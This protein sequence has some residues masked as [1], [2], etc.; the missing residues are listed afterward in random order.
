MEKP[1]L[2]CPLCNDAVDRLVYR[3]HYDTEATVITRIKAEFPEWTKNDGLCSRCLDFFHTEIVIEQRILPSVGPHFPVKTSDDFLVI[4]AG[5]RIN[6]DPRF[7]GKGVTICFIDS[8]FCLHPD[9]IITKNRIKKIVDVATVTEEFQVSSDENISPALWHGTMTSVVCSGDGYLSAGLYKGIASDAELVLIKVMNQNGHITTENICKALRWILDN[10]NKYDIRI[11][12]MSLGDEIGGSYKESEVDS[13]CEQL[14]EKGIT[15]VAAVGN[16]QHGAIKPPA[17]APDVIAVGGVDDENML[18]AVPQKLYHSSYGTT[19]DGLTKPELMAHGIWIAAPILPNSSEQKE[20]EILHRLLQFPNED[21]INETRKVQS[22]TKL[23]I[24]LYD[25]I[26]PDALRHQI[27]TRIRTCKYISPHYM[28]VDGTSFAAP[29]VTA[30]IAQLLQIDRSL[31]PKAIRDIL[32]STARRLN[33]LPAEKQ[34]FGLV[35]PRKAVLKILRR[36]IAMKGKQS[37]FINTQNKTIEFFVGHDC[38]TQVSL[39]GSFNGWAEDVLLM[40][41]GAGGLWTIEIPM[42]PAGHYQYKFLVDEQNWIEDFSN[43]YREPDGYSGF[44]SI[45]II[46]PSAN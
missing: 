42:L 38:A 44:N 1:Q 43:P 23:G 26:Q 19:V 39:A 37:P 12:N 32:F 14:I 11:V 9:L 15:I 41:P 20:S 34:G 2:I 6:A 18:G 40:E 28:H 30:V 33:D 31:S 27:L 4:P 7:T 24:S 8:G 16:E 46:E 35:Q 13:L 36:G 25:N 29:I 21:L 17:N 3:F 10:H 45:L 22:E 5:L